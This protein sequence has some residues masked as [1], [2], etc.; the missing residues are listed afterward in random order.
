MFL[1]VLAGLCVIACMPA[2]SV[3]AQEFETLHVEPSLD[4]RDIN[5]GLLGVGKQRSLGFAPPFILSADGVRFFHEFPQLSPQFVHA[6]HQA[7]AALH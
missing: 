3:W 4:L 1:Q 7:S 2:W 5:N 6:R